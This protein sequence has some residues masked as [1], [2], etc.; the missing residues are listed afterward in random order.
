MRYHVQPMDGI[1]DTSFSGQAEQRIPYFTIASFSLV[2]R[3][4][5][6]Q[7]LNT[8]INPNDF[9]EGHFLI[10]VVVVR[11]GQPGVC[12]HDR[13]NDCLHTCYPI[14]HF[15]TRFATGLPLS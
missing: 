14:G 3:N 6:K 2:G 12:L 8:P 15:L 9:L 7:S 4:S 1:R 11:L 5:Y 10:Q 13:V